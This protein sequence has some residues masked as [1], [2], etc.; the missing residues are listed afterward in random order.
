MSE[1][2]PPRAP[3]PRIIDRADALRKEFERE[4]AAGRTVGLVPTMGALHPGHAALIRRSASE[5][6]TTAVTVFVNP[7]Q[8]GVG[9]DLARY[10]RDLAADLEVAAE[11]GAT[12]VFGPPDD[13]MFPGGRSA[14]TVS[15]AGLGDGLE[16]ASRPGHFDGVA[17]VV[18]RLFNL[19]GPCRAYFGEKDFQQLAVVRRMVADLAVPV[20]VVGCRTVRDR[21]GVAWSSRNRYLSTTER[22]AATVLLRALEAGVAALDGRRERTIGGADVRRAMAD[23]VAA[24]PL[25]RLDYAEVVDP[26]G[27]VPLDSI[28]PGSEV[29][30]VLAAWIGAT[31]LI[32]NR[33][34]TAP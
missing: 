18:A 11:A 23:V 2:S 4:R 12:L 7:L 26:D 16:G 25:A 22:R 33:G 1:H 32:D 6:D 13:E 15:V 17:T 14:T 34:V 31:R 28:G 5:C 10:P 21:D 29:R 20:V 24:E 27:L 3:V 8:F 30:L 9:E 19:A